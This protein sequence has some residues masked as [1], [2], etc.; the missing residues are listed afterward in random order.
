MSFGDDFDSNTL[1]SL[2]VGLGIFAVFVC[3][4]LLLCDVFL[5]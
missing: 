4:V 2:T 1:D 3:G 5:R